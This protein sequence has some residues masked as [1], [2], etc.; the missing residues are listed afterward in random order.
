M[1]GR[2]PGYRL[3]EQAATTLSHLFGNLREYRRI[4]CFIAYSTIVICIG[5]VIVFLVKEDSTALCAE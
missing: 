3:A 2:M 5:S 1:K 4:K